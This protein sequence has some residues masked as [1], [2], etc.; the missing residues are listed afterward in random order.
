MFTLQNCDANPITT[1]HLGNNHYSNVIFPSP[2]IHLPAK[3]WLTLENNVPWCSRK[4][5]EICHTKLEPLSHE[6]LQMNLARAR[7]LSTVGSKGMQ[8]IIM[9]LPFLKGVSLD[10]LRSIITQA[11]LS[12]RVYDITFFSERGFAVVDFKYKQKAFIFY[13]VCV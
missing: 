2:L 4:S 6:D 13:I 12:N 1:S 7:S 9:F 10:C 3:S 11:G 5:I 8:I